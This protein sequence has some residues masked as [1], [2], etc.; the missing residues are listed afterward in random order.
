MVH[1]L[2]VLIKIIASSLTVLNQQTLGMTDHVHCFQT[3]LTESCRL[4]GSRESA[5]LSVVS[6]SIKNS[7]V[8]RIGSGLKPSGID[9]KFT[10]CSTTFCLCSRCKSRYT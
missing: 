8:P 9:L 3:Q 4:F 7:L 5:D 2:D 6:F 10:F 1:G